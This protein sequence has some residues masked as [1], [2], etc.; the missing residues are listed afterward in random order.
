VSTATSYE[1]ITAIITPD[2]VSMA[3]IHGENID[4]KAS[5]SSSAVT[6][7]NHVIRENPREDWLTNDGWISVIEDAV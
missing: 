2:D 7:S 6:H 3:T 4:S 1:G 5:I